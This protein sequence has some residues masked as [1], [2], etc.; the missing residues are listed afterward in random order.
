M[1]LPLG[2]RT[3][4]VV[5]TLPA[6]SEVCLVGVGEQAGI[7]KPGRSQVL[8]SLLAVWDPGIPSSDP[9]RSGLPRVGH[10][11]GGRNLPNQD[12]DSTRSCSVSAINRWW[13]PYLPYH[14]GHSLGPAAG[15][16]RAPVTTSSLTSAASKPPGVHCFSLL[17]A[18]WREPSGRTRHAPW[19]GSDQAAVQPRDRFPRISQVKSQRP[20]Q[21]VLF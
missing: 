19:P 9:R 20:L 4:T 6:V 1:V 14:R 11:S 21:S 13:W 10:R 8:E 15:A 12:N 5:A 3:A 7:K 16:G 17:P 18:K 2:Q